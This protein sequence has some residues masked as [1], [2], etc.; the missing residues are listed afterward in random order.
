MNGRL[1]DPRLGRFMQG[2]PFIQDPGNLQNYNRYAYCYNNPTTCTDPTGQW[3][4]WVSAVRPFNNPFRGGGISDPGGYLG[5]RIAH[6]KTGYQLGSIV[7]GIAS[8]YWCGDA[9][10]VALCNGAG[11]AIWSGFAG[12]SVENSLK[13][14]VIA[15]ATTY[16]FQQIGS[17]FSDG[18]GNSTYM[19]KSGT[20]TD[21]GQFSEAVTLHGVVG[22]VSSV[23]SGGKCGP[24]ALSASFSKAMI[25]ITGPMANSSPEAGLFISAVMG[26]TGSVLGGG[27]FG[28][29]AMTA[30]FGYLFNAMSSYDGGLR[31]KDNPIRQLWYYVFGTDTTATPVT[32]FVGLNGTLSPGAGGA[33]GAGLYFFPG[34]GNSSVD[35]GFQWSYATGYDFDPSLTGTLGFNKGDV[36]NFR[37]NSTN[38]NTGIDFGGIGGGGTT[39][40]TDGVV[41]GGSWNFGLRGVPA[42]LGGTFSVIKTTTCTL[43][44]SNARNLSQPLCH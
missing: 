3:S 27:K 31:G 41:T 17:A 36:S 9:A 7:I 28:N 30:S 43:G 39:I 25:P 22:C 20:I 13:T 6:N 8:A 4:F 10:G 14:G 16:A 40:M 2:D 29:G 37:G 33:V 18:A 21:Y 44:I 12:Q 34:G 38:F 19:D 26:G 11:Q 24:G 35:A 15:G 23:A 5:F 32:Y 42:M 1:F